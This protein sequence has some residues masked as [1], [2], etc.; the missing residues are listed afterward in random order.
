M[1]VSTLSTFKKCLALQ[2]YTPDRSSLLQVEQK[3]YYAK[4]T[5]DPEW[6]KQSLLY[7]F[8]YSKLTAH[9]AQI[10]ITKIA[11][12][13]SKVIRRFH[14]PWCEMVSLRKH[15]PAYFTICIRRYPGQITGSGRLWHACHHTGTYRFSQHVNQR[16]Y[17]AIPHQSQRGRWKRLQGSIHHAASYC[18]LLVCPVFLLFTLP[19]GLF[20]RAPIQRPDQSLH[21]GVL[22]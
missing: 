11:S 19:C 20:W 7:F 17:G 8:H 4:H 10:K 15:R 13:Q 5:L 1:I 3:Q 9:H 16:G 18:A 6:G 12:F 22:N 2:L 21:L 14:T